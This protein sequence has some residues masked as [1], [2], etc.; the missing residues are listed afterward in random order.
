V[1]VE[2]IVRRNRRRIVVMTMIALVNAWLLLSCLWGVSICA[3]ILMNDHDAPGIAAVWASLAVGAAC[4]LWLVATHPRSM[5]ARTLAELG[6][7]EIGPGEL[8]VVENLLHELSIAVGAPPVRAAL[9]ADDAP[10]ALAVGRRPEDTTIAVT[11]GL[12]QKL[13]RDELEAVLATELWAIRRYDTAMQ[14]V[15]LAFT[16]GA[17]DVHDGYRDNWRNPFSWV[18]IVVTFPT[19]IV[20]EILRALMLRNADFG[21]D[22]LAMA[23]TR[24][25]DALRRAIEKVRDDR[26]VVEMLSLRTAPLWFEPIPHSGDRRAENYAAVALTPSLDE[27]LARLDDQLRSP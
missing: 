25:P 27:R 17:V 23:T 14:T 1:L 24:H 10:N 16:G 12:V 15:T 19:M 22:A 26:A 3:A 11:S 18:Y 8:P 13:T 5:R 21:A 9:V 6:A 7:V 2:E 4:A 20:A